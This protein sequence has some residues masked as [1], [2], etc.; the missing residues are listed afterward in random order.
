MP[1]F[2]W[3]QK[4]TVFLNNATISEIVLGNSQKK[5]F[6]CFVE[7]K[8]EKPTE[9]ISVTELC[10]KAEINRS[11][12]YRNYYDI[13]DLE[14]KLEEYCVN[15][16]LSFCASLGFG[17]DESI[18]DEEKILK[19]PKFDNVLVIETVHVLR[20]ERNFLQKIYD[21]LLPFY[22]SCVPEV[23]SEKKSQELKNVFSFIATGALYLCS[24]A[25]RDSISEDVYTVSTKLV[26][27][28]GQ[29]KE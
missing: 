27:K 24:E 1:G 14:E 28:I 15:S 16:I 5:F 10:Q 8:K 26:K 3:L 17:F 21:R 20:H 22:P 19:I 4:G 7:L 25:P 2:A 18:R 9:K 11:T 29:I 23:L 12:F 13:F 6:S